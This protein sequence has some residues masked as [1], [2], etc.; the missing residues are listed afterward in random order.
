MTGLF[1]TIVDVLGVFVPGVLLLAG[2]LLCPPVG[3][4]MPSLAKTLSFV[5]AVLRSNVW[6]LGISA[7]IAAYVLGFLLRLGSMR[8]MQWVT[9]HWWKDRL[10]RQATC[11]GQTFETAL[12][13]PYLCNSLK[14]LSEKLGSNEPGT[15]APYFHFAKRLVRGDVALYREV[16]RLEAEIRFA[17]GLFLPFVLLFGDGIWMVVVHRNAG[18]TIAIISLAAAT[19]VFATFPS[20]RIREVIYNHYLALVALCHPAPKHEGKEHAVYEGRKG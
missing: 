14:I 3:T 11:L 8:F 1:I 4:T 16:E 5:P 12:N 9:G 13:R 17:A 10:K 19:T 20:R 2:V 7:A 6:V 18:W 15:Y